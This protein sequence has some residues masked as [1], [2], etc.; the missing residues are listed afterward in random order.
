MLHE[1]VFYVRSLS[2][3]ILHSLHSPQRVPTHSH[4]HGEGD[5][6]NATVQ[7]FQDWCRHLL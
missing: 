4:W 2:L 3:C 7:S 5:N 1:A 6:E